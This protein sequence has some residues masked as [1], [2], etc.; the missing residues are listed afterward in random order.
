M[1]GKTKWPI[2]IGLTTAVLVGMCGLLITPAYAGPDEQSRTE[3]YMD[4]LKTTDGIIRTLRLNRG[5]S[6][7]ALSDL[8]DQYISVF[9]D[10]GDGILTRIRQLDPSNVSIE[11][12]K[13]IRSDIVKKA[14]DKGIELGFIYK[15]ALFVILGVSFTLSFAA[16]FISR[17][18]VDWEEYN[19]VSNKQSELQDKIK[20]ARKEN[21]TKRVHKLQ[22]EQQEFMR[23]NMGVMFSPMKTMLVIIVPFI[24]VINFLRSTYS[25]WVVGW[26]PF[27][28]PWPELGLP[29]IGRFF[30]GTVA[31]L[32]YLGLYFLS[33]FGFSQFWRKILVPRE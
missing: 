22:Q 33:Y 20:K 12:I 10:E 5:V 21:D 31:S 3:K 30:K 26:L 7:N 15:H 18:V 4:L 23:E 25:G 29:L 6:E 9:P 24:I 32:G 17:V 8:E 14:H 16:S 13:S 2:I 11:D 19:R 1:K 28:L 27:N